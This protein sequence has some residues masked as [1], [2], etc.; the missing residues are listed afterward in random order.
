VPPSNTPL[1]PKDI[2]PIGPS[3]Q[4]EAQPRAFDQYP[5][6]SQSSP[7][8]RLF[9]RKGWGG[10]LKHRHKWLLKLRA[11]QRRTGG[12]REVLPPSRA[13]FLYLSQKP[14]FENSNIHKGLIEDEAERQLAGGTADEHTIGDDIPFED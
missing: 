14:E 3:E 10:K 12:A 11:A 6:R 9:S 2:P 1:R 13:R 4:P 5:Y 8:L 7:D